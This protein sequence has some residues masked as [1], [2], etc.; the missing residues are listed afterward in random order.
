MVKRKRGNEGKYRSFRRL[1]SRQEGSNFC[2]RGPP[3]PP[4]PTV[5]GVAGEAIAA[6]VSGGIDNGP[7]VDRASSYPTGKDGDPTA[8]D[9]DDRSAGEQDGTHAK[10]T[11][12]S[13][14]SPT[15]QGGDGLATGGDAFYR[16]RPRDE[17]RTYDI[18]RRRRDGRRRSRTGGDEGFRGHSALAVVSQ[19]SEAPATAASHRETARGHL[20]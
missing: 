10:G 4:P 8:G 1:A 2:H 17:W 6:P 14:G 13:V 16:Q 9:N 11:M 18:G 12:T 7:S 5:G 15:P 3:P 19:M 20:M